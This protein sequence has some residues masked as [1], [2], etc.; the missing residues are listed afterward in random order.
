[1]LPTLLSVLSVLISPIAATAATAPLRVIVHFESVSAAEFAIRS[2]MVAAEPFGLK[3]IHVQA[4]RSS[5]DPSIAVLHVSA[6]YEVLHGMLV[7]LANRDDIIEVE[8]DS[9]FDFH[10]T[11]P[12]RPLNE[13]NNSI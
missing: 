7:H 11:G 10:V 8:L 6:E 4:S 1:M 2:L 5:I 3:T 13:N 12:S 9:V